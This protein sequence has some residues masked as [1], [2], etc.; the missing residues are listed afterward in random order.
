MRPP[1]KLVLFTLVEDI[2]GRLV[3]KP[4]PAGSN[5]EMIPGIGGMVEGMYG[6]SA[7]SSR[8]RLPL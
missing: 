7:A 5:L 2:M 1:K 8:S 4:R 3:R 6:G